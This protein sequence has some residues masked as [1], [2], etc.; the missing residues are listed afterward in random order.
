MVCREEV[1]LCVRWGDMVYAM[2]WH[3]VCDGV[4]WRVRWDG[5]MCAVGGMECAAGWHD[6]CDGLAWCV[7]WDGMMCTVGWHGVHGGGSTVCAM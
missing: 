4:A 3:G 6:V 2:G 7:R 5:M 1:A